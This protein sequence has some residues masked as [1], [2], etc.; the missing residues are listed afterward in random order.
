MRL[1]HQLVYEGYINGTADVYTDNQLDAL[2]GSADQLTISGYAAQTSGTSPNIT[3]Q[4]EQSF[5]Q[6][7]W[8]GRNGGTTTGE[9]YTLTLA[10]G[11]E[12]LFQGHDG[13]PDNRP[14]LG[15]ARLRIRL[16]GTTP[17]SQVRIWVTGRDRA[18]G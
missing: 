3:V 12:T 16:G 4:V 14:T 9:V 2:L 18:E 10:T 5:D 15:F 6:R 17:N 11:S 7:R 8:I 1:F 13:N